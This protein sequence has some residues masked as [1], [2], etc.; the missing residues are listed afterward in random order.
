MCRYFSNENATIIWVT[1]SQVTRLG[2]NKNWLSLEYVAGY[3]VFYKGAKFHVAV[4]S[5]HE[6]MLQ[7]REGGNSEL[8]K[9]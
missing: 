8:T 5:D 6:D 1:T 4:R 9:N 7:N 3:V 2:E